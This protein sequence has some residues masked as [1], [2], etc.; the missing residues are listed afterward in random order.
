[1]A[2]SFLAPLGNSVGMVQVGGAKY[3][4]LIKTNF[5]RRLHLGTYKGY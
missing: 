3:L 5:S 4:T 2:L 1:M